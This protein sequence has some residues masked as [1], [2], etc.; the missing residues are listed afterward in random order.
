M[1][2]TDVGVGIWNIV[3]SMKPAGRGISTCRNE[4]IIPEKERHVLHTIC[5]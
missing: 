5:I 2:A 4:I 3:G 1:I